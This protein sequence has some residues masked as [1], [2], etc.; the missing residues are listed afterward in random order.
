MS[1]YR[2]YFLQLINF[3]TIF[4]SENK[5]VSMF[6][7]SLAVKLIQNKEICCIIKQGIIFL[8]LGVI[9]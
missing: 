2:F 1:K 4:V 6:G 7:G 8:F 5:N 9:L 3:F